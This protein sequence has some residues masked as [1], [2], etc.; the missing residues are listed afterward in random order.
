[1]LRRKAIRFQERYFK[2][3]TL[4]SYSRLLTKAEIKD[5]NGKWITIEEGFEQ[6]YNFN[7]YSWIVRYD[8]LEENVAG[9]CEWPT[10]L[11]RIKPGQRDEDIVLI[12]EMIHAFECLLKD[13]NEYYH[14]T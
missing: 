11:I 6:V 5:I 13:F 2:D 1:M 12:H 10:K 3:M 7:I 9:I 14:S 8:N 4:K